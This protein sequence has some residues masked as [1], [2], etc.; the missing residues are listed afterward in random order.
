MPHEYLELVRQPHQTVNPL[1]AFLGIEVTE[2][3]TERAV[4]HLPIKPEFLQGADV[5]AGGILATLLDETMAHAVLGGTPTGTRTATID[6]NISY[7]RPVGAEAIVICEARV[8]QR[9]KRIIFV[10]GTARVNER[11][12]ARSTASFL[13]V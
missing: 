2:I 9:G 13:P 6:M 4:L 8:I 5:V 7:L 3:T 12:V 11:E 1:L 10:E